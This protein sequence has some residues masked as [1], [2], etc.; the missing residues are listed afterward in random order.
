[1]ITSV[2]TLKDAVDGLTAGGSTNHAD[3]FQ[4]AMA[5]FEPA[6]SNAKVMVMFTDGNTTTGAPPAPVAAAAR[7]QGI[8]IYCIGLIGSDGVSATP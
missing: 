8:V 6:S 3:A 2:D 1:M 5:L 4:Q 7:A